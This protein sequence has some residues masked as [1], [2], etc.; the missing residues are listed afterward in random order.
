[1]DQLEIR[2]YHVGVAIEGEDML[3]EFLDWVFEKTQETTANDAA[4]SQ[5]LVSSRKSR[6]KNT[7]PLPPPLSPS[8]ISYFFFFLSLQLMEVHKVLVVCVG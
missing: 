6:E 7:Q 2:L 8:F 5:I 3:G 4:E 1:M